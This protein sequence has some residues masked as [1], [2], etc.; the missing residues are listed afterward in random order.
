MSTSDQKRVRCVSIDF[1]PDGRFLSVKATD[2][3]VDE[4]RY[5]IAML[6]EEGASVTSSNKGSDMVFSIALSSNGALLAA[7]KTARAIIDRWCHP[8]AKDSGN[9]VRIELSLKQ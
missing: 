1:K 3:S 9:S 7:L 4:Q 2:L 5:F 6:E 8:L